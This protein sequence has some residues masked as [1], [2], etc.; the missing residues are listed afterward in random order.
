MDNAQDSNLALFFGYGAKVKKSLISI[1]LYFF[2][3][4]QQKIQ[5]EILLGTWWQKIG[6]TKSLT[7]RQT[8]RFI[9][10]I[11]QNPSVKPSTSSLRT[12]IRTLYVSLPKRRCD[13]N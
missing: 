6:R 5:W 4:P 3:I 10:S 8:H 13:G 12:T 9:M 7:G 2:N 1:Q 11:F